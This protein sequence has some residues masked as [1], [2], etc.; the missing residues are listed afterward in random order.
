MKSWWRRQPPSADVA[1]NDALPPMGAERALRRL[2]WTVIRRLDGLLQGDYRTLMRGTG[3]DLADLRE[4]QHHDDVRHIDWNVTA[5]L[6]VPHVRV[7]TEDREMAAWFVLDLSRS[8]DF[9]SGLRAKREISAG[10]VGVLARLLTRH[11][12]RVGALVYG[13]D[14]EAVIPPRSGRRHVLH[15]LHSMERRAAALRPGRGMTRLADLLQ[16][17]AM[18]MPRRS[19]VFVVSDFLSEPGWETPLGLLAQRHEVVAVRLYDPLELELP[20]LG[21]VP[22]T[23]A[24]TGEQLWVDTHDAGF[25]KRFARLAAEREAT[26]RAALARAGVDAL[27]LSTA[28]DLVESIVRFADMRK[29]RVRAG[30]AANLKAV[31][32]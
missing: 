22:L 11:G 20:D 15:L 2:E 4:Y 3:L 26:L 10:F 16:S 32:A 6:Q 28:D 30:S 12:N 8:V 9:G 7:F 29:R 17:A 23:D 14:L 31:A 27:E 13:N 24:E 25:R 19:T 5:R 1:A 21:L 18:L